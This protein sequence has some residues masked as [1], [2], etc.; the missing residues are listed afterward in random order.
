[1]TIELPHDLL[2]RAPTLDDAEKVTAQNGHVTRIHRAIPT[3]QAYGEYTGIA[4]FT[5]AGAK[6]LREHFHILRAQIQF[7]RGSAEVKTF[8]FPQL[9]HFVLAPMPPQFRLGRIDL[10]QNR[11]LRIVEPPCQNLAR[12]S[13]RPGH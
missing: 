10:H 7:S 3:P 4:K 12:L 5:P 1:M 13:R 11:L 9:S 6:Q 8:I 2:L